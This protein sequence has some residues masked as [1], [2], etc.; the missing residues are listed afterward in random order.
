MDNRDF[1][2]IV[3]SLGAVQSIFWAVYFWFIHKPSNLEK[4]LLAGLFFVLG[5]RILKSTL[6]LFTQDLSLLVINIGFAA[7]LC[8][9]PILWLYVKYLRDRKPPKWPQLLHFIP[10]FLVLLLANVLRLDDFWYTGGYYALLFH[11]ILYLA[12]VSFVFIK[13]KDN[14]EP[15]KRTWTAYLIAGVGVLLLAYFSNY[16]LGIMSYLY[17]PVIYAAIVYGLSFYLMNSFDRIFKTSSKYQ[18]ISMDSDLMMTYKSKVL[19][20]FEEERSF[21]QAGYSLAQLAEETNIPKHLLSHLFNNAFNSNFSDFVNS[22]RIESS[23]RLLVAKQNRTVASVAY[24]C[25]FNSLSA[26]NNAFRKFS[27]TTP[28]EF[29]K[30]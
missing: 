16:V 9:G 10:A 15:H 29:R 18:N 28:S 5:I 12:W 11:S 14:I 1:L 4:K 2:L 24:D 17:G 23:K 6:F 20:V 22:H 25:G 13:K 19:H 3:C 30:Q 26:F 27:N 8:I 21:L 7:H